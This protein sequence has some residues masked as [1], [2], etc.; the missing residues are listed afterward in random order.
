M[1]EAVLRA[2]A[3]PSLQ[4]ALPP[5]ARTILPF[6]QQPGGFC[7]ASAIRGVLEH[8]GL[9]L[10][11]DQ[12]VGLGAAVCFRYGGSVTRRRYWVE[13]CS[14]GVD[15]A[16][17]ANVGAWFRHRRSGSAE[18]AETRMLE[19]VRA[20]IPV[21][22][23]LN[24]TFCEGV[25]RKTPTELV[26]HLYTHWAVV[27]G[28]DAARQEVH[29]CDNTR[30]APYVLPA[31]VFRQ[32][33]STGREPQNAQNTWLEL[34]LPART[35]PLEAAYRAALGQT[36]VSFRYVQGGDGYRGLDGLTRFVRHVGAW[37]TTL[38]TPGRQENA[39][40]VMSALSLGGSLKGAGRG[41]LSRFVLDAAAR[42]GNPA[43]TA[44]AAAFRTAATLWNEVYDG[45]RAV[46]EAPDSTA[47]F[48]RGSTLLSALEGVVRVEHEAVQALEAA[49][50]RPAP[51]P[52]TA[53]A[54]CDASEALPC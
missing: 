31:E 20:G 13:V 50:R 38:D 3:T 26:P 27:I 33:R 4:I 49:L 45:F 23:K 5:T 6:R 39:L 41:H 7:L 53:S 10:N 43:L 8:Q 2:P 24:P 30:F 36:V 48:A 17:F 44:P 47:P 28:W 46:S 18:A 11:E 37:G 12:V 9:R 15:M 40:R 14:S 54:A 35:I 25:M 52:E 34:R 1:S 22:V 32:A 21:A 42:L 16:L 51:R 19:L 29:F